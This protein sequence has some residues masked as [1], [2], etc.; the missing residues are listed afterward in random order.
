[1]LM[2]NGPLQKRIFCSMAR[3]AMSLDSLLMPIL[4]SHVSHRLNF[5][6]KRAVYLINLFN[7]Q[8]THSRSI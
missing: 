3:T 7:T 4:W 1:M 5:L 2:S 6:N 8:F